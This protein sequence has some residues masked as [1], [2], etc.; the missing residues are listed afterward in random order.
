MSNIFIIFIILGGL[1]APETI[2]N[3]VQ[4]VSCANS[5]LRLANFLGH[6]FVQLGFGTRRFSRNTFLRPTWTLVS[7]QAETLLQHFGSLPAL[8]RASL[9][10][11]LPFVSRAPPA[12]ATLMSYDLQVWTVREPSRQRFLTRQ[13]VGR[14][15]IIPGCASEDRRQSSLISLRGLWRKISRV[16]SLEL[17]RE[18]A[19]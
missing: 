14:C 12:L 18:L 13:S 2:A 6:F 9:Q 1:L 5:R 19:T 16:K 7:R 11:L 10:E 8:A 4:R 17:C 3:P 15:L